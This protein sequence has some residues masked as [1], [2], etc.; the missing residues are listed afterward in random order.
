[1]FFNLI[2]I[3]LPT[4]DIGR[5]INIRS[6]PKLPLLP[7]SLP[8]P[9]A[10][11]VISHVVTYLSTPT[12]QISSEDSYCWKNGRASSAWRFLACRVASVLA[13]LVANRAVARCLSSIVGRV[14]NCVRLTR[15][16]W[17]SGKGGSALRAEQI[18]RCSTVAASHGMHQPI[19]ILWRPSHRPAN[20]LNPLLIH[21]TLVLIEI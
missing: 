2:N 14:C 20:G 16:A 1:V 3:Y 6:I 15:E 18:G 21:P 13:A 5:P 11:Q 4:S 17:R 12:V 10:D 7:G 19:I 9:E 8:P